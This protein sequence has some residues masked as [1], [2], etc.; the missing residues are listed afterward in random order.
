[1][2]PRRPRDV[3]VASGGVAA[4]RSAGVRAVVDT[5]RRGVHRADRA[6]GLAVSCISIAA[7]A[8]VSSTAVRAND[9]R[10]QH[11]SIPPVGDYNIG[12]FADATGAI[13]AAADADWAA[14]VKCMQEVY[15]PYAITVTDQVPRQRLVHRGDHRGTARRYRPAD[16]QPR[17][18]ADR[19]ELRGRGQRDLVL[20]RESPSRHGH[21]ADPRHLLDRGARERARV[22]ARSRV[23][24]HRRQLD[25]P[26]SDDVSRRLRRREVLPQLARAV[27]RGCGARVSLRR[28]AELARGDPVGVRAGHAD[29]RAA[30]RHDHR[31]RRA[32]R[33]SSTARVVHATAGAQRGVA[34]VELF[35]N[36]SQ[37]AVRRRARRSDRTAS[38]IPT[39]RCTIPDDGAEQ[40]LDVVVRATDDLGISTDS[41]PVTVTKSQAV[42]RRRRLS[43]RSIV[44]RRQVRVSARRPARSATRVRTPVLPELG[45]RRHR[46]RQALRRR[47]RSRRAVELSRELHV[48]GPRRRQ[49]PVRR[50]RGRR[51]LLRVARQ[52]VGPAG[53]HR[54]RARVRAASP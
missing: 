26:R 5:P 35:L 30:A 6:A 23:R 8:V 24:V 32:A 13:G 20:V 14:V 53:A 49:G 18:R 19:G 21:D 9:A 48:S 39:T 50:G 22:R 4:A 37:W 1:M 34:K 10:T 31:A 33:R 42:H 46:R 43:R 38:P 7:P 36:G 29:H 11:S 25:V 12:E 44:H 17:R 28:H 16:R 2:V 54:L 41:D 27:R 52:A 15:S 40:H 45:V 51:L 3:V 47:L